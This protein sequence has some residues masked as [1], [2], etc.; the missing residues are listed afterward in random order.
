MVLIFISSSISDFSAITGG[1]EKRSDL[2]SSLVHIVMYAILT[3]LLV[4]AFIS[5]GFKYKKAIGYGF[6]I[7]V[8]YGITDEFHQYFV[9]GREVHVSDWL[10][11]VVGAFIVV[12]L[13]KYKL[14]NK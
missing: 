2:V 4:F 11:D 8:L 1:E 5:S 13:F 14:K 6:I 3:Y 9:P 7:A 10:L 12:N